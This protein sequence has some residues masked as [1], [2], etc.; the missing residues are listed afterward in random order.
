MKLAKNAKKTRIFSMRSGSRGQNGQ[1]MI[2][3]E[4][5]S[6][7]GTFK[8]ITEGIPIKVLIL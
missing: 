7:Y 3:Y 1:K 2:F 8:K 6:I 4:S 5:T